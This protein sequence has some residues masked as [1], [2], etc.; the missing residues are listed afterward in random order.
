M[1][2]TLLCA[3][4]QKKYRENQ[5]KVTETCRKRIW[6]QSLR[7]DDGITKR[8]KF[9]NKLNTDGHTERAGNK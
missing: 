2:W 9:L 7:R 4:C 3:L 5:P 6:K 8:I 1:L